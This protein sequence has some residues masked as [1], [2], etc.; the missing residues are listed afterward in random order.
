[1]IGR[2]IHRSLKARAGDNLQENLKVVTLCLRK[3]LMQIPQK[4]LKG[5]AKGTPG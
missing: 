4:L 3:L 2:E 1:M 5:W